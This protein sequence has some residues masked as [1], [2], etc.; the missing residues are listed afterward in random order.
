[1][2]LTY[3]MRCSP[4]AAVVLVAD[5]VLPSG[6]A[7]VDMFII[8]RLNDSS[9]YF[10]T[11]FCK[12]Y[13]IRIGVRDLGGKEEI[14]RCPICLDPCTK[15]IELQCGH[16]F[17]RS[18]LTTSAANNITSC[19]LCRREQVINPELL[20][21]RFDEERM[22][23]LAQRLAIPP[24]VLSR[25]SASG[26]TM[27]AGGN[28]ERK[29]TQANNALSTQNL[30]H[31]EKDLQSGGGGVASCPL[32]VESM[33]SRGQML[34]GPWGDV[35][36]MSTDDLRRRWKFSGMET[37]NAPDAETVGAASAAE[38][39]SSWRDLQHLSRAF[40]YMQ[41]E[42]EVSGTPRQASRGIQAR[43]DVSSCSGD[44]EPRGNEIG[45]GECNFQAATPDSPC[46]GGSSLGE[47][48]SRWRTLARASSA[49]CS[50][51]NGASDEMSIGVRS[52]STK[53]AS[54]D[55]KRIA[56]LQI[57]PGQ[58]SVGVSPAPRVL[59]T[60]TGSSSAFDDDVDSL[61]SDCLQRRWRDAFQL[62]ER[63]VEATEVRALAARFA[64]V[65]DAQGGGVSNADLKS[66]WTAARP[67]ETVG[68]TEVRAL[69]ARFSSASGAQ[70]VG[71]LPH[72]DLACR[73]IASRS[74][75]TV[76]ATEVKALAARLSLARSAQGVGDIPLSDL[77][78]RWMASRSIETVG[79]TEVRA[80]SAR[81]S[82]ARGEQGVGYMSNADLTSRWIASRSI[83]TVGAT[84]VGALT[85]RFSLARG[86]QGVGDMSNAD[87][88][89]RWIASRSTDTVGATEVGALAARFLLAKGAQGVGDT[90]N[91]E[92]ASRWIASRSN[93][94]VGATEVG[95]LEARF[96]LANGAQ[97]VGDIFNAHLT[98]RWTAARSIKEDLSHAEH[99]CERME[100]GR[101]SSG[102]V[103]GNMRESKRLTDFP[104]WCVVDGIAT[105]SGEDGG[106]ST[107]GETAPIG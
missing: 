47:L 41:T 44:A 38:L 11:W 105:C 96:S 81:F 95:A 30:G 45:S 8:S 5:G 103:G 88:T 104:G 15:S 34:F 49:R 29:D 6:V 98:S 13:R 84:E 93:E 51:G 91:A 33:T 17:C 73:W 78:S 107:L 61:A 10:F 69:A 3:H 46:A 40:T 23:N 39:R 85:A 77:T 7:P 52:S 66:R 12:R 48:S 83:D 65:R 59:A 87:L 79:A 35:G 42:R 89:N 4:V 68:A 99:C 27:P 70:G 82:L 9:S 62:G 36:A 71:D 64:M 20:R 90:S 25:P 43:A 106:I 97:G 28:R 102:H 60:P 1:M 26:A 31:E 24:P 21:A 32:N 86:E 14:Q 54:A 16:A 75:K 58:L 94:T 80:L 67:K 92:L 19:A 72:S 22:L 100:E 2:I 101:G 74:N 50:A 53:K 76:G 37:S 18:C 63:D 55:R 57:V 56:E